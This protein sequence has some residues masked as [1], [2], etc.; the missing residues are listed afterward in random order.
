MEFSGSS[1]YKSPRE[2]KKPPPRQNAPW[3]TVGDGWT[4]SSSLRAP[5]SDSPVDMPEK[6][7]P[8]KLQ[9]PFANHDEIRD[10]DRGNDDG[11]QQQRGVAP[12]PWGVDETAEQ[13][14]AKEA[15]VFARGRI[16]GK[17]AP[18]GTD[19]N[20]DI[21]YERQKVVRNPQTKLNPT[22]HANDNYRDHMNFQ[23]PFG[24]DDGQDSHSRHHIDRGLKV[25]D[26]DEK[27]PFHRESPRSDNSDDRSHTPKSSYNMST[28]FA[29]D[30]ND[31]NDREQSLRKGG[32]SKENHNLFHD[33][34]HLES[35]TH[36]EHSTTM[37]SGHMAQ[38]NR[39]GL[40]IGQKFGQSSLSHP[41]QAKT[42]SINNRPSS[43]GSSSGTS[44][45]SDTYSTSRSYTSTSRDTYRDTARDTTRSYTRRTNS[46]RY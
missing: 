7:P 41:Q 38:R 5:R 11:R 17:T 46:G 20:C 25:Y 45:T 44:R 13:I 8:P 28:P 43:Y 36:G 16:R 22:N 3:A 31:V 32:N 6:V 30:D 35:S 27:A 1:D 18:F 2:K 39:V 33:E 26:R 21:N 34:N 29:H 23:A 15:A 4:D 19:D 24:T 10:P 37:N 14:K 42:K 12:P 40:G 9:T